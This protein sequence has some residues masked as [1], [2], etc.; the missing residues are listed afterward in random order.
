M[1][2]LDFQPIIKTKVY[3][4][5]SAVDK[6]KDDVIMQIELAPHE[7]SAPPHLHPGQT[8]TYEVLEGELEFTL[9][10]Q[11]RTLNAGDKVTIPPNTQH[12]FQND[13]GNWVKLHNVH[14]PAL[15]F[16]DM[17]R[18]LHTLVKDGKIR[19]LKDFK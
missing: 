7:L 6:T 19:S 12:T 16:E 9:G 1:D 14:T 3:V 11:W 2:I 4:I 13:A 17:M 18:G 10:N 8:E 5:K 15:G